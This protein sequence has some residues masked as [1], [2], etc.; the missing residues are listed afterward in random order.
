M[1]G[2]NQLHTDFLKKLPQTCNLTY[3]DTSINYKSD[4]V[5]TANIS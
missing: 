1:P 3:N 5:G 4:L 2:F